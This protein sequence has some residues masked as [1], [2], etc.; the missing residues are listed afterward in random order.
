MIPK[1]T[2]NNRI[3]TEEKRDKFCIIS[4]EYIKEF[5][6]CSE[7]IFQLAKEV[8]ASD[9]SDYNKITNIIINIDTF[10]GFIVRSI[11][12]IITKNFAFYQWGKK[13]NGLRSEYPRVRS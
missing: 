4:D 12:C 8:P 7:G 5:S 10:T 11:H 2:C 6:E 1:L 9:N 13:G 3:L